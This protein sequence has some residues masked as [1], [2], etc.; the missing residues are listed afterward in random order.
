MNDKTF[1]DTNVLV[2]AHD[3]DAGIKHRTAREVV[4]GLWE[5]RRG[6]VSTQ[7]LQ[8]L[9]V[10]LTRKIPFP[11]EKPLAR[12]IVSNYLNWE[13]AVNDGAVVLQASE[14]EE[15]NNLSFWDAMIVAA[16][17]NLNAAVLL[18][19]DLNDGQQI[20]GIAICNPFNIH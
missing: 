3:R 20:E 7:V 5:T 6:A 15:R 1:V 14:I 9:Y 13:V 19:E 11:L 8:E 12:R 10:T 16:A 4:E 2:Y 17:Y 18:T